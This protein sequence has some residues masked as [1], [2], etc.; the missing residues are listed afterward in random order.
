M[1]IITLEN[2]NSKQCS[3]IRFVNTWLMKS[4]REASINSVLRMQRNQK[5]DHILHLATI[6]RRIFSVLISD[7][8]LENI[9]EVNIDATVT[10]AKWLG[11]SV[12]LFVTTVTVLTTFFQFCFANQLQFSQNV[13]LYLVTLS[14]YIT[15]AIPLIHSMF[16]FR[17][18]HFFWRKI[19]ETAHLAYNEL[20]HE[21]SFRFFWK[22]F[23][24]DASICIVTLIMHGSLRIILHSSAT[25]FGRQACNTLLQEIII[26]VVV[27]ALFVVNLSSFFIRLLIKYIDSDHRSRLLNSVFDHDDS[28][29]HQLRLYKQFH[30][31]LWEMTAAINGFFGPTL[32]VLSCHAF[33]EV[34][35][36]AYGIF[37]HLA[38]GKSARQLIS[39]YRNI[40]TFT[41]NSD[42]ISVYF[43]NSPDSFNCK[44]EHH[45]S[46]FDKCVSHLYC[47][48]NYF[49]Q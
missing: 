22:K 6:Y 47:A 15:I 13:T 30:Y 24:L 48:G 42:I 40:I 29:L 46:C 4:S 7:V 35:Y 49:H 3:L 21:I 34:T 37:F 12:L 43:I 20:G 44:F 8:G 16:N 2:N 11:I 32:L 23:L 33:V 36:S 14:H 45:H 1:I 19:Y 26:Y 28:L 18:I 5:Y 41:V 39:I 31:K 10:T 27:H 17:K 9:C 25:H 38:L